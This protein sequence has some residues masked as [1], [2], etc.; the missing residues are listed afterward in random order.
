MTISHIKRSSTPLR[1]R[2]EIEILFFT[3]KLTKIEEYQ[4]IV[5]NAG[6]QRSQD[7]TWFGEYKNGIYSMQGKLTIAFK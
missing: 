3:L 6:R 2:Y 1:I 4:H 5:S 7:T